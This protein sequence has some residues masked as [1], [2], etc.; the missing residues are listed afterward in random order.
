MTQLGSN[1]IKRTAV[2]L[3]GGVVAAA[4]FF[5]LSRDA[6]QLRLPE[7]STT[8]C[9]AYAACMLE[10]GKGRSVALLP[11]DDTVVS[12]V[13]DVGYILGTAQGK[14]S[15]NMSDADYREFLEG[16]LA[17]YSGEVDER[18]GY[19]D[20]MKASGEWDSFSQI[21]RD[22]LERLLAKRTA[23]TLDQTMVLEVTE[24]ALDQG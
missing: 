20:R 2:F 15:S 19:I 18:Q 16:Q 1:P 7:T 4:L 8:T 10:A 14:L 21:R 5:G 6:Q 22:G 13:A 24:H 11:G 12:V 3:L 17:E 23:W 9:Q